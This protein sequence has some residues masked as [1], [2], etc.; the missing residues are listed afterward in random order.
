M[1]RKSA[2]SPSFRENGSAVDAVSPILLERARPADG[3]RQMVLISLA[4]H[5]IAAI[6]ILLMPTPSA[7]DDPL[8][9]VMTISLSSAPGPHNGGMTTI[10]GKA[11][12][13]APLQSKPNPA[14]VLSK[15][16]EMVLPTKEIK[17]PPR[18]AT[19]SATDAKSRAVPTAKEARQG[20]ARVDTGAKSQAFGLTTGGGG[21]NG[22]LDV[23]NFCCPDYLSQMIE[24]IQRNW[25]A[26]QS[27]AGQTMMKFTIQ[28]DGRLTDM[29]L[30]QSSGYFALDQTAQRALLLTRQLPP[31]P[32]QFPE[33]SLTV[34]LNF[35]YER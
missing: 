24:L 27:V 12:E 14:A 5:G 28:R 19:K 9:N 4:A 26:K 6:G 34:H 11:A 30:E 35:Q 21:T 15:A 29:Q 7:Q 18:P 22:H 33:P 1:S 23:S 2:S 17:A 13:V 16:P 20:D 8:K 32:A 10:G 25:S 3:L 31:L